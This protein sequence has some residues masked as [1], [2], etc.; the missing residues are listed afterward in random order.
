MAIHDA[1][2]HRLQGVGQR[3][4]ASRRAIVTALA[5]APHPLSITE[6]VATGRG[7]AVSSVYRN[8]G[9]LEEAG[10]VHRIDTSHEF[11]RYELAEDL[12]EHHHHLICTGCGRVQDFTASPGLERQTEQALAGVAGKAGFTVH[13]HRIDLVG[14]CRTCA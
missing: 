11:K 10:V 4:T 13:G 8:L 5:A 2:S 1:V 12:T 6:L 7:L 14:L 3:Y 9:V